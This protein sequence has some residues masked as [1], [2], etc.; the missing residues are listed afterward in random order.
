MA[1]HA[2]AL[3][4]GPDSG[5][6]AGKAEGELSS[7]LDRFV[8]NAIDEG[9]LTPSRKSGEEAAPA[10]PSAQPVSSAPA[11]ES[12]A[13]ETR[14]RSIALRPKHAMA[15]AVCAD[16]DPF[17]FSGLHGLRNYDDLLAWRRGAEGGF[18]DSAEL[19]LAKAYIA[20]G[21]NE[22]AQLQLDGVYGAQASA[23]R[24]LAHMMEDRGQPELAFFREQ[25]ACPGASDIWYALALTSSSPG[26]AA[27]RLDISIN[28][29]RNLPFQLRVEV[30]AKAVPALDA[31][32]DRIVAEKMMANFTEQEIRSSSRLSF[33]KALLAMGAG[34]QAAEYAMR[35]Y[36]AMPAFRT[37]ATASL[38]RHG[39]SLEPAA[40]EEVASRLIDE[41]NEVE[42]TTPVSA[43]LDMMLGELEGVAGYGLTLQLA[44]MEATQTP[45]AQARVSAHFA[46]LASHGLSSPDLYDNL[47]AMDALLRGASLLEGREGGEQL[48]ADSARLAIDLGWQNL[49][50]TFASQT[51]APEDLAEARASLAYRT[52]D[53][54]TVKLI[55]AE[56]PQN[57]H[58][59]RLAALSAVRAGDGPLMLRV[60]VRFDPDPETLL[61]MVELDAASRAWILPERFYT[62]AASI[63]D[64]AARKRVRRVT[65]LRQQRTGPHPAPTFRM[66]EI[67]TALERIG[68]S[69]DTNAKGAF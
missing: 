45:E 3:A 52:L 15:E 22:E 65:R 14:L 67:G 7:S 30:A 26:E 8:Q 58:I 5:N 23:L 37:D 19:P 55:A 33:N 4:E 27:K 40:K 69:L 24:R 56:Y 63:D 13:P 68:Q 36:L 38:L 18:S 28:E 6:E 59:T 57:P 25:A 54:D 10:E 64:E 32:G 16:I 1:S 29:F 61:D 62:A 42:G 46:D 21:L 17:D 47:E 9:L 66:V 50:T 31:S 43:S 51:S 12:E 39:Y 49:A 60:A 41:L 2:P 11:A 44:G 48:F 35:N 34:G 53:H 20:L